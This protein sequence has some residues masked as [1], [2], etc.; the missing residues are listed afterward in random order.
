MAD[1]GPGA[2]VG[3]LRAH[4]TEDGLAGCAFLIGPD[5]V[6]T[7]AHVIGAHLGLP[8]P[9]PKEPP[10][11]PVTI[12]FEAL[13]DE[14][15]GC[16]V[17]FGW[18][19]NARPVP[20]ELSDIAVLRLDGPVQAISP[21]PAIAQRM[22]TE[23]RPV[24]IHGAEADYKSYG[25]QVHGKISAS[26]IPRGWRQIDPEDSARGFTVQSGFSGS[27]VLDD[28]GNVVWGMV[29]A[30][31][32]QGS[33]VAYA[34]PADKLWRALKSAGADT[35]VRLSD[36]TD[37]QAETAMAKLRVE[38]EARLAER[39][40]ETARMQR[41]LDQLRQ[42]VRGLKQDAHQSPNEKAAT[43]LDAL[44]A[45]DMRPATE[46]LRQR[47]EG[48]LS[49]A[50]E[51]RREAAAAA[52]Q[53]GTML[54]L[55]D[56]AEALKAYRR[57]AQCDPDDFWTWIEIARLEQ[58]AGTLDGARRATD[59]ALTIKVEDDR[60]RSVAFDDLGDVLRVQ[61][62]LPAALKYYRDS[63][64][65]ADQLAASD[66]GNVSWQRDLSVSLNK[67]GD[68]LVEQGNL[69]EALKSYRDSLA[70][71]DRL[72][73][74]DPGNTGWRRDLSVAYERVGDVLVAQG[75]LPEA[76]KSYRYSLTIR[77]RLAKSDPSNAGWRRDLSV[78]LNKVGDV[79]AAQG[80]LPGALKSYREG[81]GIRDR[82]AKSDPG[83]AGWQRDLSVSYERVGD[84][85]T[86]QG[87]LPEAL[88]SYRDSLTI[89]DRLAK[90]DPD[91]AG[92][93]RDLSV[94]YERLGEALVSQG[95]LPEAL[96][97]YRDSLAIADRLAK[98]D[99]GNAGWQRDL[100]VAYE[101]VGDVLEAQ[102]SLPE[103]LKSYRD[104]LAIRHRLANSDLGNAG[105]QR[106]LSVSYAKLAI[107]FRKTGAPAERLDALQQ[108]QEIIERMTKLSPE[109]AVWQR[110]LAWFNSQIRQA[111]H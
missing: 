21:L 84:V 93:Q 20:G 66:P 22:P 110:D 33:G 92:W 46:L 101:R 3:W 56:A 81:L 6:L 51:G 67:L 8:K 107:V 100:S 7:C 104:S 54:K 26:D 98:S 37:R 96:T 47:M 30:V 62:N 74:S 102:G 53:L 50:G 97:A 76:L 77:H 83:N 10:P 103:A 61:G 15:T 64:V 94:S 60:E 25:Q 75:N 73:E 89:R 48:W 99:S 55:I 42:L 2:V 106:D 71:R 108:G 32:A 41:E 90:S 80:D 52:R 65:I 63:L 109:N 58:T 82:L 78:S 11:G 40:S 27:P 28:L 1:L 12:R 24:L 49:V 38:Y 68:L 18:F 34:I 85:L 36:A 44:A 31:A 105:W 111:K 43:A 87:H 70:I 19:G 17:P 86:L 91:N 95:N 88:I 13:Q 35:A 29:V 59:A 72:A 57:A 39:E 4:A 14:V 79:L 45:G 23:N 5:V 69:P 9:V 16:V